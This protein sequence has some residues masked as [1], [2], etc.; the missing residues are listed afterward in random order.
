[1]FQPRLFALT[2]N[3]LRPNLLHRA[4]Q[5]GLERGDVGLQLSALGAVLGGELIEVGEQ[6]AGFV[7]GEGKRV[8]WGW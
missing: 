1:M 4:L 7:C 3:R 2:L 6:G 5:L 8:G